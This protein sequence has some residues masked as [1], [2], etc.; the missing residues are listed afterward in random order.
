MDKLDPYTGKRTLIIGDVNTGKTARSAGILKLFINK[1]YAKKIAILDLGT[2]PVQGIGGKI[3]PPPG[4]PLLYLTG[5]IS[6]P[7]L[8]GK[9]MNHTW[10]LANENAKTI[11]KM[12]VKLRQEKREILFVNDATLYLQAGRLNR[13]VEILNTASTQVINAYYGNAFIDSELTRREKK[14]TEGLMR[15]C[16]RV[17]KITGSEG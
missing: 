1:G 5:I 9:N 15:V 14:L 7:R 10:H 2:D 8:M 17:I 12:F 13:F 6:P 11:E 16:D 3:Q 4:A